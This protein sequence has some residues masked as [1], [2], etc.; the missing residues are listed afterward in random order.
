MSFIFPRKLGRSLN[1]GK[2]LWPC[3]SNRANIIA[4]YGKSPNPLPRRVIPRGVA[5]TPFLEVHPLSLLVYRA[6]K[7]AMPILPTSP[8][9][10]TL[11]ETDTLR[12][13]CDKVA[14]SVRTPP[15][16]NSS[17]HIWWLQDVPEDVRDKWHVQVKLAEFKDYDRKAIEPSD[18]PLADE[19]IQ[20]GDAFMV[21]FEINGQWLLSTSPAPLF[22][23][24][25]F[26]DQRGSSSSTSSTSK[27]LV[28]S[29]NSFSS[30]SWNNTSS[31]SSS[32]KP[33]RIIS[34]PIE[35]GTLGLGNL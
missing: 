19:S 22:N 18:K 28:P 15:R 1:C 34:A 12:T 10:V 20:T 3:S 13:L 35:P 33:A 27:A 7:D 11:S 16:A 30:H 17:Y 29:S 25:G 32:F 6:V 2:L 24:P 5:Q 26:F 14:D 9:T 31:G 8:S 21:E 4:R 23:G